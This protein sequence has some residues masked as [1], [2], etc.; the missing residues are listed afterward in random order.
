MSNKD[1]DYMEL[2]NVIFID[3]FPK[4]DFHGYDRETARVA[5]NDFIEENVKLKN[6]VFVIIHGVGSGVIKRTVH[7]TLK[8][9]K[10]V[11]EYKTF[12]SNNGSTLV[13]I[14]L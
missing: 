11:I 7:E 1:S 2:K 6:E 5:T 8:R 9:N 14:K 12:Y 13:R 10:R 4:I 3:S